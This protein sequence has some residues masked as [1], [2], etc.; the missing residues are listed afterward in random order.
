MEYHEIIIKMRSIL[1]DQL[2]AV[3]A[4]ND[5]SGPHSTIVSFVP[6]D[7]LRS[8]IF[9][10]PSSTRKYRNLMENPKVSF[11]VD[12]RSN[13]SERLTQICG[14]E[15]RGEARLLKNSERSQYERIYRSRHPNLDDFAKNSELFCI[16][17]SRYDVVAGFQNVFVIET[18]SMDAAQ[19]GDK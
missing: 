13:D 14:I 6:A 11:F 19:G 7:D 5:G 17:V 10:T 16:D 9:P 18:A 2:Y 1:W 4:T 12:D 8:I 15:A 3:L